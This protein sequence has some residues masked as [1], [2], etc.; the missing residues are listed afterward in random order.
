MSK[1]TAKRE[2]NR[3]VSH[4]YEKQHIYKIIEQI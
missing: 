1:S 2:R 3:P 4:Y